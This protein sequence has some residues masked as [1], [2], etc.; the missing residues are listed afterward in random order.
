MKEKATIFDYTKICKNQKSCRNCPLNSRAN[1]MNIACL[2][3][4]REYTNKANECEYCE[5]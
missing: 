3:L 4:I 1:G 2:V 5:E